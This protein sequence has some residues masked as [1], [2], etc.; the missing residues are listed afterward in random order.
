MNNGQDKVIALAAKIAKN[1]PKK[2]IGRSVLVSER[3][4][5]KIRNPSRIVLKLL[6][7]PDGLERYGVSI[8]AI[9]MLNSKACTVS[10]VSISKPLV[11]AGNDFANRRENIR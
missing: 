6:S 10:S 7:E 4:T 11:S 9:G 1:S 8:S 5:L 2:Y 3:M